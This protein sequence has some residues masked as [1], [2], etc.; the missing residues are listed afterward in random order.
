MVL[1]Q[2]LVIFGI[3]WLVGTAFLFLKDSEDGRKVVGF[4][5]ILVLYYLLLGRTITEAI[6]GA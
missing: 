5:F 4:T 2:G 6:F 3:L 1:L